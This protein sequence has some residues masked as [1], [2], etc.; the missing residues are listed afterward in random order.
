MW[1]VATAVIR[2]NG[3]TD[4]RT[5]RLIAADGSRARDL[6]PSRLQAAGLPLTTAAADTVPPLSFYSSRWNA[7]KNS[8]VIEIRRWIKRRRRTDG[9]GK[10]KE[11]TSRL[12]HRVLTMVTDRSYTVAMPGINLVGERNWGENW[13]EYIR[14]V[15]NT[16]NIF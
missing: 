6:P 1:E 3:L 12:G 15:T 8:G 11:I 4:R 16:E 5:D 7:E 14:V 2:D 10:E 9:Q 13:C